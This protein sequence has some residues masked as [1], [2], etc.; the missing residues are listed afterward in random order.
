MP[1]EDS[2]RMSLEHKDLLEGGGKNEL[3]STTMGSGSRGGPGGTAR[4]GNRGG[5]GGRG[6]QGR[7]GNANRGNFSGPK[8]FGRDGPKKTRG[9]IWLII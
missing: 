4:G 6:G 5:R 3:P 1:T 7:G 2:R 9:L 8:R